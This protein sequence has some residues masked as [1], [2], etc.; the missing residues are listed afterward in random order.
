MTMLLCLHWDQS[1]ALVGHGP[2]AAR[3]TLRPKRP[4][5]LARRYVVGNLTAVGLFIGLPYAEEFWRCY[6]AD[7]TLAAHPASEARDT[8]APCG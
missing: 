4:G 5:L 6:R 7:R 3:F 1:R 2:E 8:G